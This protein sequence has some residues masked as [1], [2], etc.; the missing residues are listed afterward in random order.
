MVF[1]EVRVF[2]G[3]EIKIPG[4]TYGKP[5]EVE[6]AD[7]TS[8]VDLLNILNIPEK[9]VFATLINGVHAKKGNLLK[10]GDRVAFFPPVG[11]G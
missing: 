2:A 11:G 6:V 10:P 9:L 4:A 7:G 3:L 1:V 8:V 5:M